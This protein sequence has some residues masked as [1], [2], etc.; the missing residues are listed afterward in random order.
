ML[1]KVLFLNNTKNEKEIVNSILSDLGCTLRE[2]TIA[3]NVLQVRLPVSSSLYWAS[4]QI[5]WGNKNP[6]F[7]VDDNQISADNLSVD[8]F[9]YKLS[10]VIEIPI[11][12]KNPY[13]ATQTLF[14]WQVHYKFFDLMK[15]NLSDLGIQI[16]Q[17][18]GKYKRYF[19]EN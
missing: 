10:D 16:N 6:K 15:S 2:E 9:L 1:G 5:D 18:S 4:D 7:L 14:D 3:G 8:D 11:E 19:I 13:N 17:T 12:V